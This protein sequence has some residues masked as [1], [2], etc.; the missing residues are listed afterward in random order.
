MHR[1]RRVGAVGMRLEPAAAIDENR[2]GTPDSNL[3]ARAESRTNSLGPDGSV[4]IIELRANRIGRLKDESF[5]EYEVPRDNPM[6]S[7]LAVASDG[8]VWFAMLHSSSLGRLGDG[9]VDIFGLP[10]DGA[11]PCSIAIDAT[12]NVWYP[13]ISGYVGM[14][15]VREAVANSGNRA[16]QMALVRYY[17]AFFRTSCRRRTLV[18]SSSGLA[19]TTIRSASS[20]AAPGCVRDQIIP[21][22]A[23][24][25]RG[26]D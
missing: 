26:S 1:C 22:L 23:A 11:R 4:W 5:E 17:S 10:R 13:D 9:R 18:M 6:L 14:L 15:P 12:G 21:D 20:S 16:T 3:I 2:N 19:P 8:V 24:G 25:P 7:G